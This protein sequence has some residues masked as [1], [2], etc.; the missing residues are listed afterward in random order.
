MYT[1]QYCV[2]AN[3]VAKKVLSDSCTSTYISTYW[4]KRDEK[5]RFRYLLS[6]YFSCQFYV[7]YNSSGM[8]VDLKVHKN[9]N[10]FGSDFEFCTISLL[11]MLKY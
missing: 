6:I 8:V 1:V 3:T 10:F 7:D 2:I 11:A 4:I 5:M 9:E